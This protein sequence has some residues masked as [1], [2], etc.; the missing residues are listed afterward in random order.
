[1]KNNVKKVSQS[2]DHWIDRAAPYSKSSRERLAA[3][4]YACMWANEKEIEGDFVECGVWRGGNVMVARWAA[5]SRQ[6]WV[7]DTFAG[8]T[9]P[10]EFDGKKAHKHFSD[11]GAKLKCGGKNSCVTEIQF[12]QNMF[13]VCTWDPDKF[14]I[15]AGDVRETLKCEQNLPT[16]I[17][18]LRLD[19]DFYDS[20]KIELE[21]LYPR[22]SV[23]G[24][25][26]VDDYGH[27]PGARKAVDEY[28]G[29]KR[30]R[31]RPI[32]YT[33]AWMVKP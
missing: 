16:K 20:T 31:L 3:T 15:I 7:Y 4:A 14:K 13:T 11:A 25:L 33:G 12:L 8:M 17:S 24:Y 23:G 18:V 29:D 10:G 1:M 30:F 32:D 28:L 27:W 6:I 21:T 19:T 26:I 9:E 2:I 22:L 5:P